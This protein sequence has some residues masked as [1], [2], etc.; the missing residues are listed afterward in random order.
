MLT[1]EDVCE[2]LVTYAYAAL[3]LSLTGSPMRPS[4]ISASGL[5]LLVY[6]AVRY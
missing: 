5:E 1:C 4:A 6:A 2:I 3:K